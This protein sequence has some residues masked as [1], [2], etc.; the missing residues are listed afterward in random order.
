MINDERTAFDFDQWMDLAKKDPEGFEKKRKEVIKIAIDNAS[1][2]MQPR[3]NGLQWCI[4]AKIK[5]SKNP[6]DGCL[7]VFQM[8]MDS[9]YRACKK[10]CVTAIFN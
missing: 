2:K 4:D 1:Q 5:A 7:K 6:M 3:L 9:I 10:F 8:M